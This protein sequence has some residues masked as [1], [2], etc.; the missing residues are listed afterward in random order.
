MHELR[1]QFDH[2]NFLHFPNEDETVQHIASHEQ[3]HE[4]HH[5]KKQ[6][7]LYG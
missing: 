3:T 5:A 6:Q 1:Y 2:Y 4:T 7:D